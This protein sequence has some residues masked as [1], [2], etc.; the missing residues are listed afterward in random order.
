V[1]E[2]ERD[3]GR[4]VIIRFADEDD[5]FRWWHSDEHCAI[6]DHRL[7]GTSTISLVRVH[8]MPSAG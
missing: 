5:C 4:N 7:E 6:V 8:G 3:G 1:L 2:G